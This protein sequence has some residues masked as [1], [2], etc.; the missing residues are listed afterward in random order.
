MTPVAIS[1]IYIAANIVLLWYLSFRVIG[2]RQSARVSLGTG[3]DSELEI[4]TRVHGNASEYIPVTMLALFVLASMGAPGWA[5]HAVG[6][7]FTLGRVSHAIG[8][9]R[10]V[11]PLRAGGMVLTWLGMLSAAGGLVW[12]ALR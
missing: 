9:S 10:T 11:L 5:I 7:V 3:G 1:A 8:L 6:A 4:R 2:R 12:L